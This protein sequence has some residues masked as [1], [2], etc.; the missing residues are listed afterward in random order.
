MNFLLTCQVLLVLPLAVFTYHASW[1]TG[2]NSLK[3]NEAESYCRNRGQKMVSLDSLEKANQFLGILRSTGRPY[4]WTGGKLEGETLVW[5]SGVREAVVRGRFPWSTSG[6]HGPQP[7][8]GSSELCVA[9]LNIDFYKDGSK[10]HDVGCD[11]KK[12][13]ICE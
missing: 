1:D 13:V 6:L 7:D 12:P 4:F 11:H 10:M 2:A 5:P 8:G 3:W 9:V